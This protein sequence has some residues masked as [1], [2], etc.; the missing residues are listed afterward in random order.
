MSAHL[1]GCSCAD[2]KINNYH[3]RKLTLATV[4][5]DCCSG[6]D[7]SLLELD[8]VLSSLADKV[9]LVYNQAMEPKHFPYLVDITFV[10]G[11]IAT[12]ADVVKIKKIRPHTNVLVSI[13][14]CATAGGLHA[15]TPGSD[16]VRSIREV[17]P[18]DI[19]ISGCP[20][21]A[22]LIQKTLMDLVA[23]K[24]SADPG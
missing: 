20:P 9:E 10:E 2:C 24:T 16:R 18:V 23:A 21:P 5:L 22:K 14:D 15:S 11:A 1:R 19:Y 4:R 8:H 3:R 12:E 13:G 7:T 17:I 6:C